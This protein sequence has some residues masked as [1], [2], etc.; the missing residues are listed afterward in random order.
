MVQ[1]MELGE[2][3][4][5]EGLDP[6]QLMPWARQRSEEL[7]AEL[8]AS[9][10]L[11]ALVEGGASIDAEQLARRAP[12][13][14]MVEAPEPEPADEFED[15]DE[16]G[17]EPSPEAQ[18][19][20]AHESFDIDIDMGEPP[21]ESQPESE[22]TPA[23]E[24]E[25]DTVTR[26]RRREP[27]SP[28]PTSADELP[29]PPEHTRLADGE[30]EPILETVDTRPIDLG[31]HEAN[32]MLAETSTRR[33]EPEP[34]GDAGDE[35]ELEELELE[36][37]DDFELLEVVD[38]EEAEAAPPPPPPPTPPPP[39]A[40]EVDEALAELPPVRTGDTDVHDAVEAA[41]PEEPAD[42]H[43]EPDDDGF[44]IDID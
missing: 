33:P 36:E 38:D 7:L 31:T 18:V 35:E 37:L 22:P 2:L 41:P 1:P 11:L 15:L 14:P 17:E 9:D 23:D 40:S 8:D 3:L 44:D 12:T 39:P 25:E 29:P 10:E 13:R 19:A 32:V 28:Q 42:G 27:S 30:P 24:P 16:G 5:G 4:E 34:E 43:A 21:L 6:E 26:G 20:D